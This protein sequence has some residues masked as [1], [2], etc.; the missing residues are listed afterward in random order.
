ML[1]VEATLFTS[2]QSPQLL[3]VAVAESDARPP[4]GS[5]PIQVE[6]KFR[7][8]EFEPLLAVPQANLQLEKG[9][10][11]IFPQPGVVVLPP[12]PVLPPVAA[13]PPVAVLPPMLLAPAV[14]FAPPLVLPPLLVAPPLD[15]APPCAVVVP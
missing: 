7:Y 8:D 11:V 4:L 3:L 13:A 9:F 6:T 2:A 14:D 12:V 15:V 1:L 10:A 5:S